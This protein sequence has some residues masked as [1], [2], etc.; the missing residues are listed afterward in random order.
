MLREVACPACGIANRISGRKEFAAGK[1]GACGA[2]LSL[3]APIDLG[4]AAFERHLAVTKG[5]LIVDIWAPWCGPCRLMAPNFAGAAKA[6]AGAARLVKLNA[7]ETSTPSRLQVRGIPAL[8]MFAGG[9]E[10]DRRTGLQTR[11]G[12]TAWAREFA[13]AASQVQS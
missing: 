8:I 12:I 1:C 4:D 6:L 13:D 7:D 5:P 3:D 2:S 10:I 9:K 11:E